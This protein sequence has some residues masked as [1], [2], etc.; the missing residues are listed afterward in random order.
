MKSRIEI[1]A[2]DIREGRNVSTTEATFQKAIKAMNSER[3][4]E[5][6]ALFKDVLKRQ[7]D[8]VAA[9]NL[10]TIVL[11][12]MKRYVE[13]EKFISKAVELNQGSDASYYNFGLISKA[14][15][16]P[17]QALKQFDNALRLKAQSPETWN[18]RGTVFNDLQQYGNAVSDFDRAIAL[19]SNYSEAHHNRAKSL[20]LLG[21]YD[22]AHGAYDKA[23]AL[24]PDLAGAWL[25]HLFAGLQRYDKALA[26]YDRTLA[27]KPDLIEAWLG[28]GN[29]LVRLQR[30]E[31]A[32]GA[33]DRVLALKPDLAE[34]WLGRGNLLTELKRYEEA[35]AAY[36][37]AS[38]LKPDLV[39][40]WLSRG[41]LFDRLGRY[42][43]VLE[44]CKKALALRP[45][46]AEAWLGCGLSLLKLER[47]DEA[48]AAYDK[49]L[50][51][52][53]D[54]AGAWLGR[55][56][57]FF[58]LERS[59]DALAAYEKALALEPGLTEAWSGRGNVFTALDRYDEALAA[60]DKAL[61]LKP[62]LVE[63]WLGR[64]NAFTGLN[65]HEE[66]LAAYD[67][68]L[69]LKTDLAEAWLGRGNLFVKVERFNEAPA[70]FDRALNL[71]PDLAKVWLGRGH[72]YTGLRQYDE[73]LAAYDKALALKP[74]LAGLD[75][76]RLHAK[77][78]LCNWEAFESD[79]GRVIESIRKNKASAAPFT[80]LSIP[81]SAR[82]QYDCARSWTDRWYPP[83]K[84][85][86]W[87]GEVYKHDKIRIGYVSA[88]F[89]EHPV[90]YL[91]AGVFENHDK[92]KF[93]TT[94]ISIG[95]SDNSPM[96]RRLEA[97]FGKFLDAER[98][99]A[100][101][102]A[103]EIR[104]AEIDVL[105]DLNGF[106]GNCRT[107]IFSHRPAPIQVN[108]LGYPG[109]MGADFIDYII[110]DRTVIPSSQQGDFSE[111]IACLPDSFLAND[112]TRAISEKIFTRE[113]CGLPKDGFVFCSFNNSYKIIPA[114]FD[115]WMRILTQVP[116]S[117]LWLREIN[118]HVTTNLKKE[119]ALRGVDAG[120]IIFANRTPSHAD[121]LARHR[122]AD[123]FLDT[124]PYNAHTTAS[125]ALWAG[126]PVL[127]QTGETFAG[128]VA[129]S[130][131]NAVGLPELVAKTSEEYEQLAIE[132]AK[133]P[134]TLGAL[135]NKL[136]GNRLATAL[137]DTKRFTGQIEATYAAMHGR[138]RA[139]L[140]PENIFVPN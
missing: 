109:T 112:S 4:V 14:L 53:P 121:H 113:D 11:M 82:D 130:L 78:Q 87:D 83:A 104:A 77:M 110:A 42:D 140:A 73:A 84:K 41:N 1:G 114:V 135:K 46:F 58:K 137:F 5:A 18:N 3:P 37:K 60:C 21:R 105:V 17:H 7:P 45:D 85:P 103:A 8:N 122:A 79:C 96:R 61:A 111:K 20:A 55:G 106:T 56:N 35:L 100:A 47:C 101:E 72:L 131:L 126:L 66:A 25:G 124:L 127:T 76:L 97:A 108:Y 134:H 33:H 39:E 116:G 22:D 91:M 49:A 38:A 29:V 94:A 10:L 102:I 119:A 75:G 67:K 120:R 19:A 27:L 57:V 89:Q 23:L 92:S 26:I 43:E 133:N 48:L 81:S 40:I 12:N 129:A 63:A 115:R 64:G 13:A 69:A 118:A 6:E 31:E 70:A 99:S 138:Y 15:N 62:D 117:V 88:D 34:A 125:D 71:K 136:A 52:K 2:G 80:F 24:N 65:R 93:E 51:L 90:A 98:L 123:L 107:N 86:G 74:D 132:I 9:L 30:Y 44:T 50:A 59:D 32:L 139:G 68:A 95:P 128:K 54:L 28:R 36:D 16:K